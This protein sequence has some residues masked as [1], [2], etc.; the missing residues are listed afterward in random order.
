[1]V[2]S[3]SC[4][5]DN[6]WLNTRTPTVTYGVRG[7]AYFEV[8]ISGPAQDLHS[9]LWG[10]VVYEPMTDLVNLLSQLVQNTGH[11]LIDGAYDGLSQPDASEL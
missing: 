9:G 5:S 1:M 11:I 7:A 4:K 10:N 3:L 8:T 2:Y 6:Y